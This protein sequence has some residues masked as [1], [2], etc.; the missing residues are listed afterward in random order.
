MLDAG[1]FFDENRKNDEN[2]VL[3]VKTVVIALLIRTR[4]K[5]KF[6]IGVFF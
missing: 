3:R 2:V 4:K 6:L 1:Y 5:G